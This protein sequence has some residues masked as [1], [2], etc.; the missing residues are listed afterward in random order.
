MRLVYMDEAGVSSPEQEPFLVVT[1][2]IVD[3]DKSLIAVERYLDKLAARYIP[4][5]MR[6]GFIFH[7]TELF[8]GRGKVFKKDDSRFSLSTRLEIADQIAAIPKRFN[9]HVAMGYVERAGFPINEDLRV[10]ATSPKDKTIAAHVTAFTICSMQVEHWMRKNASNEV[11]ML[12]VEDNQ[13]A[14]TLIKQTQS[15][16]Q[17]GRILNS[18]DEKARLHFPLRKIKEDPLFQSKRQSSILIVADFFAYVFKRKMMNDMRNQRFINPLQGHL[19][20]IDP[21]QLTVKAH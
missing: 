13:Q 11:C 3:A 4:A 14:R 2:I 7:A 8:G 18:L 10:S 6:D 1:G 20:L 12:I 21:D 17:D 15:Y 16:H 5:E 19:V 9:L